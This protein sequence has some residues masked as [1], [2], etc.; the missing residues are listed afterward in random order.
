[1]SLADTHVGIFQFM[2]K[3]ATRMEA[4]Q[5]SCMTDFIIYL[6]VVEEGLRWL[7]TVSRTFKDLY[8]DG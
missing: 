8:F 6:Q 5:L 7:E 3:L 2:E 4:V 1:M